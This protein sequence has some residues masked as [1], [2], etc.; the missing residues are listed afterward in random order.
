MLVQLTSKSSEKLYVTRGEIEALK[1]LKVVQSKIIDEIKNNTDKKTGIIYSLAI[2]EINRLNIQSTNIQM[3]IKRQLKHLNPKFFKTKPLL[4][5]EIIGNK[6]LRFNT[7]I[8]TSK[9]L[10]LN[11]PPG[12]EGLFDNRRG[13]VIDSVKENRGKFELVWMQKKLLKR[14]I[15]DDLNKALSKK[16]DKNP[17]QKSSIFYI[18][19]KTGERKVEILIWRKM[20]Q[21]ANSP[22]SWFWADFKAKQKFEHLL[23]G[24][25]EVL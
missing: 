16:P 19:E 1:K 23:N 2:T 20:R 17:M 14:G 15:T 7:D 24:K 13:D 6:L 10:T 21:G 25:V 8:P 4:E 9:T 12:H 5:F 22:Y 3:Q 18:S 11:P